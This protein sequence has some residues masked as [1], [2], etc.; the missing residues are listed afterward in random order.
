M[1]TT[2]MTH[3]NPRETTKPAVGSAP[4]SAASSAE[5]PFKCQHSGNG[6]GS[7]NNRAP[8]RH[9]PPPVVSSSSCRIDTTRI[10][11]ALETASAVNCVSPGSVPTTST[12]GHGPDRHTHSLLDELL[13]VVPRPRPRSTRPRRE[14]ERD[15]PRR[16]ATGTVAHDDS[17]PR[18]PVEPEPH[19]K[20]RPQQ[21][22]R[23]AIL[24]SM[25]FVIL[26]AFHFPAVASKRSPFVSLE[27]T[28]RKTAV[29]WQRDVHASWRGACDTPT[30]VMRPI[31]SP[32]NA[33]ATVVVRWPGT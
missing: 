20:C 24:F 15:A 16:A 23:G 2:H 28:G 26:L 12:A 21:S 8:S 19:T 14:H 27:R 1:P 22:R 4:H 32:A 10:P 29:S 18:N 11:S 17:I 6:P 33:L 9:R 13:A 30:C 31:V 5:A 25:L 3:W 7:R